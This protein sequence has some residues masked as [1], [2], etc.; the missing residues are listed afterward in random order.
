MDIE[1][2]ELQALDSDQHKNGSNSSISTDQFEGVLTPVVII[3]RSGIITQVNNMARKLF[4]YKPGEMIGAPVT[5]LMPR[6]YAQRHPSYLKMYLQTQKRKLMGCPRKLNAIRKGG[7]EFPMVIK[8]GEMRNTPRKGEEGYMSRGIYIAL[9]EDQSKE[10]QTRKAPSRYQLDFVELERLGSGAFGS[11]FKCK[12]KLDGRFY[13]VKKIV[14]A[15]G[16]R[17]RG[18][19]SDSSSSSGTSDTASVTTSETATEVIT[20]T[21]TATVTATATATTVPTTATG[22]PARLR[23]LFSRHGSLGKPRRTADTIPPMDDKSVGETDSMAELSTRG[24]KQLK[25]GRVLAHMA[26]HP[27]V[28]RYFA[29]WIQ[30][31]PIAVKPSISG[32]NKRPYGGKNAELRTVLYI[33]MELVAGFSLKKW[34]E[35][36]YEPSL[37]E[38]LRIMVQIARGL[39]HMHTQGYIHRDIK[40]ANI[41]MQP[42]DRD[43]SR[44]A[45][46]HSRH[47]GGSRTPGDSSRTGRLKNLSSS[48]ERMPS[49]NRLNSR[50]RTLSAGGQVPG[51]DGLSSKADSPASILGSKVVQPALDGLTSS[52]AARQKVAPVA[53]SDTQATDPPQ[54]PTPGERMQGE[55][56]EAM[57][58]P[59]QTRSSTSELPGVDLSKV[60]GDQLEVDKEKQHDRFIAKIADFGLATLLTRAG[61]LSDLGSTGSAARR[62][63][64]SGVGTRLYSAPE[65]LASEVYDVRADVF[66]LGC[67]LVE[68][69]C[70]FDTRQEKLTALRDARQGVL[71][72]AI[73]KYPLLADLALEMLQRE[74]TNRPSAGEVSTIL[75]QFLP[76][77][78]CRE[79]ALHSSLS[80]DQVAGRRSNKKTPHPS[81][82]QFDGLCPAA[83]AMFSSSENSNDDVAL[84][85]LDQLRVHHQA[86]LAKQTRLVEQQA[87]EIVALQAQLEQHKLLS[88]QLRRTCCDMR[89]QLSAAQRG[90]KLYKPG[91]CPSCAYFM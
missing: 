63:L 60:E 41:L 66:A 2:S 65:Q 39:E 7:E 85:A 79:L 23:P 72:A 30:H 24:V 20:A 38:R 32:P 86:Q 29:S 18:T 78:F 48:L 33:Q 90:N 58:S 64:T 36:Q 47:R 1:V 22:S 44:H 15:N 88:R 9:I 42:Y 84:H 77:D 43:S 6:G 69:V 21:A 56:Q 10:H 31:E 4:K 17:Q 53:D 55:A 26:G 54:A 91:F 59:K 83:R 13:A 68:I 57:C 73:Q 87:S 45:R 75:T 8:L 12:N 51:N 40:P 3:N 28:V 37:D 89:N 27:N 71:P 81:Q 19:A 82:S 14:M 49:T 70:H 46:T 61:P 11:V 62:G 25:E 16:S 52:K 80:Q 50:N 74:P 34:L 76:P 35:E 67:V 5:L